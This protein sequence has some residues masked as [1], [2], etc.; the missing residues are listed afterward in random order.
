MDN[1]LEAAFGQLLAERCTPEV[2]RRI[3]RGEA[4]DGLWR[5][6][7]DSGFL[8]ALVPEVHGG[9]GLALRDVL[10]LVQACGEHALP[11][12]FAETMAARAVFAHAGQTAPA[13]PMALNAVATLLAAEDCRAMLA[14][15][16]AAL[17][18]GAAARV[19]ALSL[20]HAQQRVQFG[21][22]IGSFQAVQH[23]LAVMAEQAC[24]ARM[25]SQL[26]F[27][28]ST[29]LPDR[30]LAAM[31]MNVAG[32][33][34]ATLVSGSHAV[35]G[36]IGVTAEFDLQ[37]YTR[38]L[39]VWRTRGGS[40]SYWAQQVAAQWHASGGPRAVDFALSTLAGATP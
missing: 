8:D 15:I 7:A 31:A 1:E 28:S 23:Q 40:P 19:L 24:A 3:E 29:H 26:A 30:S 25:A 14:A 5:D 2:V 12:P 18:A 20:M 6:L 37:L 13:G 33:A 32:D 17:I 27:A 21:K 16:N 4:A 34:A 35:H 39:L 11:L 10:P 9:A 36:A 22:P 38:R